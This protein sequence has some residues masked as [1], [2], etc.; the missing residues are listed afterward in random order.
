MP[1]PAFS[2]GIP[3]SPYSTEWPV[4]PLHVCHQPKVS[5]CRGW[6]EEWYINPRWMDKIS[7][8]SISHSPPDALGPSHSSWYSP[9][10]SLLPQGKD[11]TCPLF[12][13]QLPVGSHFTQVTYNGIW[14]PLESNKMFKAPGQHCK[15]QTQCSSSS[16]AIFNFYPKLG[17][18]VTHRHSLALT[19]KSH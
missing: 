17:C 10:T 7:P 9:E 4:T 18:Q 12:S 13:D 1:R 3:R 8:S 15:K 11:R 14:K 2:P 16:Q 19:S 6:Q 5:T